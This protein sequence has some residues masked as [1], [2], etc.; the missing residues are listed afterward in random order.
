[1]LSKT[2]SELLNRQLNAELY[3]A[4]L[5][6]SYEN[7]FARLG[8][9]GFSNWYKVQSLEELDHAMIFYRYLTEEGEVIR[10]DSIAEV[11]PGEMSILDVLQAAKSHELLVTD[12]INSLHDEASAA[13]DKRTVCFLDW[14]IKEQSEEERNASEMIQRYLLFGHCNSCTDCRMSPDSPESG[15]CGGGLYALNAELADRVHSTAA[16][17]FS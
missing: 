7:Y 5:Y 4:Y 3:S 17:P 16:Y 10:F 1:M 8:L 12:M 9:D 14:F 11:S 2:V 13:N 6:L 15:L